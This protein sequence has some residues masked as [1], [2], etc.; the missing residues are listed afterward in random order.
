M[1]LQRVF[2]I[3]AQFFGKELAVLRKLLYLF[4]LLSLSVSAWAHPHMFI[5][6]RLEVR[7]AGDW[8]D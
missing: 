5:D 3:V 2:V 6:T 7:L 1:T 8:R 4:C